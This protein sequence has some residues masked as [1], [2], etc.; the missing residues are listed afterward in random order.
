MVSNSSKSLRK[1]FF[2]VPPEVHVLDLMG[3]VHIFYEA[4][5]YG[6][7]IDLQFL[8]LDHNTCAKSSAGLDF[9][10]LSYFAK[11][12]AQADDW[13]FIPGIDRKYLD[14]AR[15][16]DQNR[17]FYAWLNA[18]YQSGARICSVCTG[19]F[20]LAASGL[21]DGRNATTHWKYLSL[22]QKNY[23]R[24]DA[25]EDRLFVYGEGLYTSAGVSSGI[26][27][28]LF[29]LEESYGP[30]FASDIAKEV[31]IY[32]R[33]GEGDPQMSI[34]LQYRNHLNHRV[35]KV[36]DRLSQSLS[37]KLTIEDLADEVFVSPRNLTRLFKKSTGITIGQYQEKLRVERAVQLL[38]EGHKLEFVTQSC[39]LKSANQLRSLLMKHEGLLPNEIIKMAAG[40]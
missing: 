25:V 7:E 29:L 28:A 16:H 35:H 27:L 14:Q 6:A 24:V 9:A 12:Q 21:L 13:V 36:Q 20:L 30:K 10:N 26:D 4:I 18:Q 22:L 3:P 1:A 40:E 8:S 33:R 19:A 11:H 32:F 5:N 39:G 2:L 38:K 37:D 23:P 31:V 34:F 17:A 15:F